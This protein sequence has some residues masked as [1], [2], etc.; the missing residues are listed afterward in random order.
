MPI[1][2]FEKRIGCITGYLSGFYQICSGG[3]NGES[4]VSGLKAFRTLE[5]EVFAEI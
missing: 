4:V 3:L 5:I 1:I 2:K